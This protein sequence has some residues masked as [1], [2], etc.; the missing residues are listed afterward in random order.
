MLMA[1]ISVF[2]GRYND[3]LPKTMAG[4]VFASVPM[5]ILCVAC[6]RFYVQGQL[7]G[8]LKRRPS[9]RADRSGASARP[10]R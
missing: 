4:M 7:A 10:H 2:D 9:H 6:Q 8:S 1:G 3:Q 5:I